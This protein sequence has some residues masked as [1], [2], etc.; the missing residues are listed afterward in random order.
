[1]LPVLFHKP[2]ARA[3]DGL[4]DAS[5]GLDAWEED[6]KLFLRFD[7]PGFDKGSISVISE[8][9]SIIVE[10]K[11]D[12]KEDRKYLLR[13]SSATYRRNILIPEGYD[14]SKADASYENGVLTVSLERAE[15]RKSR[16]IKIR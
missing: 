13:S 4:F 5:Y 15:D 16:A 10:A 12:E 3:F 7:V 14:P 9:G 1:M 2:L 11:K 6:D 8:D